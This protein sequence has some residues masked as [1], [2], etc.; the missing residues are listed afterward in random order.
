[1]NLPPQAEPVA[2]T[3]LLPGQT[4]A[5]GG[6][7]VTPAKSACDNLT[8]LARQMCYGTQYGISV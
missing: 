8:G 4:P 7:G 2:R 5:T 3:L 1:M 6:D